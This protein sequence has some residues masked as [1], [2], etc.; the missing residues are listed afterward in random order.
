[1]KKLF[2]GK[3]LFIK[4]F[5]KIYNLIMIIN[6]DLFIKYKINKFLLL[7]FA[8]RSGAGRKG[9]AASASELILIL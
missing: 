8:R 7:A 4:Y 2:Y 6:Y 9:R 1:M 5:R 3:F